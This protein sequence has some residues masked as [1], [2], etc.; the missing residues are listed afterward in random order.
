MNVL[1]TGPDGVLGSNLLRELLS[2]G[3][4]VTALVED[5]KKSPTIDD[6]PITRIGGNLLNEDEIIKHT[7]RQI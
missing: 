6:L 5:G 4:K 1:V 2:Q 3:Y 7:Y